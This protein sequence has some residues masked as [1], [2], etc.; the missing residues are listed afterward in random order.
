[1]SY[2][3]ADNRIDDIRKL[4]YLV[5]KSFAYI[6]E[7]LSDRQARD[8]LGV[9]VSPF[10]SA[11]EFDEELVEEAL[12]SDDPGGLFESVRSFVA[13]VLA[14]TREISFES[15][16]PSVLREIN[17]SLSAVVKQKYK[18]EGD[19]GVSTVGP[20]DQ[21]YKLMKGELENF[22]AGCESGRREIEEGFDGKKMFARSRLNARQVFDGKKMF[23]RL[24]LN[25][26]QVT[27]DSKDG[28]QPA[29]K[30]Y[31][32]PSLKVRR[33][34][35]A[36]ASREKGESIKKKRYSLRTGKKGVYV[37]DS[38]KVVG[39]VTKS[40]EIVLYSGGKRYSLR[41]G[42]KGVYVVDSGKVVGRITKSSGIVLYSEGRR[43]ASVG[44]SRLRRKIFS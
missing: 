23:A 18:I 40:G 35:L 27:G 43:V 30:S 24:R 29:P 15:D 37:V 22:R 7:A 4:G 10:R 2:S 20:H 44:V 25:V 19:L 16:A 28:R 42:K 17:N 21:N 41:T 1:M 5:G 14:Y 32:S 8:A 6:G 12:Q 34:L 11:I 31:K 36:A 9:F 38:G 26:R 33:K 3:L 39:R 13:D